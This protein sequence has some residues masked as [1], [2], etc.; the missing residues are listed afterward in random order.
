MLCDDLKDL[1]I[2]S[3]SEQGL[4]I[5]EPFLARMDEAQRYILDDEV[6]MAAA[7]LAASRPSAIRRVIDLARLPHDLM[8]IEWAH[9]VRDRGAVSVGV[10]LDS[11]FTDGKPIPVRVGVL[12]E[13][14]SEDGSR[15]AFEGCWSISGPP[16][17]GE[18]GCARVV[19]DLDR[20]AAYGTTSERKRVLAKHRDHTTRVNSSHYIYR[21]QPEEIE[22]F[23]DLNSIHR[24]EE[25]LIAENLRRLISVDQ[26]GSAFFNHLYKSHANDLIDEALFIIGVLLLFNAPNAT[27]VASDDLSRLNRA[28]V[29]KR[30]AP[31]KERKVI[32]MHLSRVERDAKIR[33]GASGATP[34]GVKAPHVCRGHFK[35]RCGKDGVTRPIW[36]RDHL[37]G[38][39]GKESTQGPARRVKM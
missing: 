14:L 20:V 38:G 6:T 17:C 28:R 24:I 31:L 8:W 34:G 19:I 37:R 36:W 23:V 13:R 30:K 7:A 11:A 22:A 18:V 29:R 39:Y 15:W 1:L 9:Q 4:P 25:G 12:L 21:N 16:R 35:R 5:Y 26:D 10:P 2:A 3:A 27:R 33:P 32:T